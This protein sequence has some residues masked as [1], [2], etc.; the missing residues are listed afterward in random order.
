MSTHKKGW[1]QLD[2]ATLVGLCLKHKYRTAYMPGQEVQD[3]EED[4]AWSDHIECEESEENE[5]INE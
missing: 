5:I 1:Q 4:A 3:V 2:K